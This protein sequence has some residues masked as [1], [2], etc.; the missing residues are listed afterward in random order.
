MSA[1]SELRVVLERLGPIPD[2]SPARSPSDPTVLLVLRRTGPFT[3]RITVARH[4][5]ASGSHLPE[6][7]R[8]ISRLASHG[9]ATCPVRADTDLRDLASALSKLDV[10]VRVRRDNDDL[11]AEV[12]RLRK[13]QDLSQSE[14]AALLNLDVRTLQ[15]WEQGRNKPDAATLNLMRAFA[16]A[17]DVVEEAISEPVLG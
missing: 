3:K 9:W 8:A 11:A 1:N 6:A 13:A 15:N 5:R 7:G 17:P 2:T 12:V 10:E 14:Y 4:L 16:R